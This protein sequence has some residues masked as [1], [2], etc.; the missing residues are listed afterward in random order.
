MLQNILCSSSS[1]QYIISSLSLSFTSMRKFEINF[2]RF[3]F[4]PH[5]H[6]FINYIL[7]S[8]NQEMYLQH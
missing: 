1:A 3:R 4:S 8:L 2:V 6:K 7:R 5:Q